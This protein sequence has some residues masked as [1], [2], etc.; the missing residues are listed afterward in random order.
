MAA[1]IAATN[2]RNKICLDDHCLIPEQGALRVK[3]GA[4]VNDFRALT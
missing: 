2:G 3:P 4:I 1:P